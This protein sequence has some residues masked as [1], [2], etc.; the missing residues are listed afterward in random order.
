MGLKK[1]LVVGATGRVG[2]QAVAALLARGVA[3]RVLSRSRERAVERLGADIEVHEGDVRDPDSLR[4][5]GAGVGAAVTA[6]GTRTYFGKNGNAAVDGTGTRN[7]LAALAADGLPHI[8]HLSAWGLERRSV[9]LSAFSIALNRYFVWKA[10]AEETVR[11]SGIPCTIV[12][13]VEFKQRPP[14]GGPLL[15][16][17]Q[18]L[19]LCKAAF[20][21][22]SI[23][24][25]GE[26]LGFCAGREDAQDKTFE[27]FEGGT[28]PLDEQLAGLVPDRERQAPP[29]TPLFGR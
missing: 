18:P 6:L 1:A 19:S 8:V 28:R 26:V 13:P 11:E 24:T 14:R 17:H 20:Q 9:F 29:R 7:V 23:T 3:V 12:R 22:V 27:L 4:G 15:N 25:V 16:Q 5:L 2:R 21:G 10:R